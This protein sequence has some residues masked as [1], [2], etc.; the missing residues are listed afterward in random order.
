MTDCL[1]S[2]YI[3]IST[4]KTKYLL[5]YEPDNDANNDQQAN[6]DESL[7]KRAKLDYDAFINKIKYFKREA[8]FFYL[9]FIKSL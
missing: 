9:N 3:N 6:N 7:S 1:L 4:E 8:L 5:F 2:I